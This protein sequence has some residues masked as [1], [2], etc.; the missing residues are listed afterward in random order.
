[1]DRYAP[2]LLGRRRGWIVLMQVALAAG[3]AA[4]ALQAGDADVKGFASSHTLPWAIA[5]T[6]MLIAFA[7]ASQD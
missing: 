7:A 4:L 2:P 1:M 5:A 3:I 6:A